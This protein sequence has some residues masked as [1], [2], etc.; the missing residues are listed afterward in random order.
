VSAGA[1][2]RRL[3]KWSEVCFLGRP[4]QMDCTWVLAAGIQVVG[5]GLEAFIQLVGLKPGGKRSLKAVVLL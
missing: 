4:Q 2:N 3:N 5:N 1:H